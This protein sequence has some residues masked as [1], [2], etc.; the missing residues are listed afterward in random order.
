MGTYPYPLILAT[1]H[2]ILH[3]PVATPSMCP[4]ARMFLHS[5]RF[6][7][8]WGCGRTNLAALQAEVAP[9]NLAQVFVEYPGS[10]PTTAVA[11]TP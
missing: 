6:R 10:L 4:Y 5:L 11:T 1:L 8:G 7:E 2:L 3:V 9:P